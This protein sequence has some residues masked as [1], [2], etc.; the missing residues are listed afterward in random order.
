[1]RFGGVA[2][3]EDNPEEPGVMC[4]RMELSRSPAIVKKIGSGTLEKN[5]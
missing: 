5:W 1:M 4:L 2:Y 3:I